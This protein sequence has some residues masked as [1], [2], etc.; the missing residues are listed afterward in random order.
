MRFS[1]LF[2]ALISLFVE[3]TEGS[4]GAD[5]RAFVDHVTEVAKQLI[6]VRVGVDR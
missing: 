4:L 5:R 2:G 1:A 3:W 6:G